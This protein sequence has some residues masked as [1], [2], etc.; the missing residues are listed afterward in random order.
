MSYLDDMRKIYGLMSIEQQLGI[1]I[2]GLSWSM[3][4]KKIDVLS[5]ILFDTDI[6]KNKH[7]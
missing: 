6:K 5:L 2:H 1:L 7:F 3:F 4:Y